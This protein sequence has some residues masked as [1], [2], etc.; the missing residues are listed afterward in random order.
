MYQDGRAV[1]E[2]RQAEFFRLFGFLPLPGFFDAGEMATIDAEYA[3]GLESA[4]QMYAKGAFGV[5]LQLTWS[6]MRP[7]T[8]FLADALEYDKLLAT[9]ERLLGPGAVG[10]TTNGNVYSGN[11]TEWHADKAVPHF[12]SVKFV[13]YLDPVAEDSG[14]LRVLPGSHRSPWHEELQ[15]IGAKANLNTA[16]NPDDEVAAG[17]RFPVGDVPAYICDSRPGDVFAFDLRTWH[18]S[19]NGFPNRRMVSFTYF[20]TPRDDVERE[21]LRKVAKL[22]GQ[23]GMYRELR[24][25]RDWMD[26][27]VKPS[28]IPQRERQYSAQWLANAEGSA[29][30]ARWIDELRDWGMIARPAPQAAASESAP[31]AAASA[32]AQAAPASTTA[33]S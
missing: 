17:A 33:P 16:G 32:S 11:Q 24:R 14:A 19:W 26:A 10:A 22:V 9:A 28:R 4:Q 8:P 3:S 6:N 15:P 20:G 5:R 2:E 23:E 1:P 29:T 27:G 25:Q 30:R 31:Q 13:T 21:A 12:R 18:A 7:E